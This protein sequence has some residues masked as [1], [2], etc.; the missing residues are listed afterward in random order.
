MPETRYV[1]SSRTSALLARFMVLAAGGLYGTVLTGG[2]VEA[3]GGGHG[4]YVVLAIVSAPLG[5][6]SVFAVVYTPLMWASLFFVASASAKHNRFMAAA[7]LLT[8][9]I[10]ATV[11]IMQSEFGGRA[12]FWAVYSTAPR[13]IIEPLAIYIVGQVFLWFI[14]ACTAVRCHRLMIRYLV[15]S[16]LMAIAT[17]AI[18]V[19]SGFARDVFGYVWF[20]T[21]VVRN[22]N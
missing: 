8:Q 3:C 16:A 4:T 18:A 15:P 11:L 5:F 13:I 2:A 19:W 9:Y 14:I 17:L 12:D 1:D 21:I 7:A 6:L 10:A 22:F 20:Y